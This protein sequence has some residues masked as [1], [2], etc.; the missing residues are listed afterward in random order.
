M[1]GSPA[2]EVKVDSPVTEVR[3]VD[4]AATEV[5]VPRAV[6]VSKSKNSC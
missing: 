2:T 5:M 3:T 6:M 4:R 1:E